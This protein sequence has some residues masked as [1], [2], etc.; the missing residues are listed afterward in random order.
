MTLYR[1]VKHYIDPDHHY[2]IVEKKGWFFWD[3]QGKVFGSIK[4][5]REWIDAE[6]DTP[7]SEIMC[8]VVK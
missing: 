2:Y 6:H 8:E 5:A 1:I 4:E 3:N 7:R